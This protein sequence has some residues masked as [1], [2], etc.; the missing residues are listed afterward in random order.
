MMT[1]IVPGL[2][3]IAACLFLGGCAG[4]RG[5][6]AEEYFSIGMAYFEIA[7]NAAT[8]REHFFREAERWLERARARDRTMAASAY[9]MGRLF[10]E[11][12]RFVAAAEAFGSVL[13]LDPYN[14]LALRAAAYTWIRVGDL[15]MAS[16]MYGRFLALVPESADDGY[17][18]ALVLFAMQRYDEAEAVLLR[19]EFALMDEPDFLLLFART[20]HRQEKPEAIDS[21]DL[22]LT[23][24]EA[25]ASAPRVRFEYAEVLEHWEH[26]ARALEEFR[27]LLED[28]VADS[29]FP[30]RRETRFA[31]ARILL[32]ADP[33]NAE[34]LAELRG[35]V[36]YGFADFDAI[37]ALLDDERLSEES[38]EGIQAIIT[39]G[40]RTEAAAAAAAA[41][42]EEPEDDPFAD[43]L[44]EIFGDQGAPWEAETD[45]DGEGNG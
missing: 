2:A 37:E 40:R 11:T 23:R 41:A 28:L 26:Y 42:E 22:W 9:N 24:N 34:G 32:V 8:N 21:F 30:S 4:M 45:P 36:E 39:E 18:H 15:E 7:Q 10:F 27:E 14:V 6:P 12:G 5:L 31:I 43:I 33:D 38:A 1:R 20:Q 13:A 25:H 19:N 3:V 35:A 29:A 44:E 16:E 17:N